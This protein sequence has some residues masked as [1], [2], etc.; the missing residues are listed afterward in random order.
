MTDTETLMSHRGTS[1]G[2]IQGLML[3]IELLKMIGYIEIV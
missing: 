3:V 1:V 2:L